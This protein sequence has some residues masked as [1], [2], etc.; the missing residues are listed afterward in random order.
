[1]GEQILMDVNDALVDISSV[2]FDTA[3]I[4]YFVEA[5]PKYDAVVAEIFGRIDDGRIIGVTSVISLCEVLVQPFR[6]GNDSLTTIYRNV[7]TNSPNFL[8][9]NI[10]PS[11]AESAALFRSRYNLR[12]PDALQIATAVEAGCDIFLTNDKR[13]KR[14]NE[15]T[16][17]IL[18]ELS[19]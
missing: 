10:T 5:N 18:E 16:V 9:Q 4:I 14:V 17:L 11:I 1:M 2:A 19:L 15:L 13:L 6:I 7:L 8:T 12:T 3:P